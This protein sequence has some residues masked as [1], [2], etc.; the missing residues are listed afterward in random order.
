MDKKDIYEHLANI[1]LDASNNKKPNKIKVHPYTFR[2]MFFV[3]AALVIGLSTALYF[4][5]QKDQP[6]GSE[7]SLTL[8]NSPLKINF[9]FLPAKK[10]I[11]ALDLNS[12][13]ISKYKTL[14]FALKKADFKDN[15]SLK[16][17]FTGAFGETSEVYVRDIG[18]KWKDYRLS[19]MDFKNITDWSDM[20]RLKFIVE[21][22]N[23]KSKKGVIY[24][25]NV[26]V[27]K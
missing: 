24:I 25:D 10:E 17:E 9:D 19:L 2:S 14:G 26:R 4:S 16:V 13:N 1:Y 3:S 20:S 5:F 6:F 15:V 7:V 11:Y 21:D 23:T 22:W 27:I 8:T 18:N 12:L